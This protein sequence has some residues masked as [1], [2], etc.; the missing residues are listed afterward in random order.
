MKGF[1]KQL[2]DM[3]GHGGRED[4]AGRHSELRASARLP[5][6]D[7]RDVVIWGRMGS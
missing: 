3:A 2:R 4:S 1:A 5:S 7:G 6:H